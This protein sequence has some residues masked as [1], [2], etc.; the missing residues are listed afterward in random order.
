MNDPLDSVVCSFREI[1]RMLHQMT[2]TYAEQ[3]GLTPIQMWILRTLS[4]RGDIGI[5]ELACHLQLTG[6]AV[7]TTVD[8]LVRLGL[9]VRNRPEDDRRTVK[10]NLTQRGEETVNTIFGPNSQYW[11][12]LSRILELPADDLRTLLDIHKKILEKLTSKED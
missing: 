5:M 10:I 4:Q 9:V 2:R 11:Q 6:G 7:S 3:T 12:K 1:N 8:Q